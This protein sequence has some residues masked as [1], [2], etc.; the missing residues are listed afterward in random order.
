MQNVNEYMLVLTV[1]LV[2]VYVVIEV[3]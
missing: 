3:R 2:F 1:C